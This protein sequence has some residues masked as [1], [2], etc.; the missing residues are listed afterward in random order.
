M[1]HTTTAVCGGLLIVLGLLTLFLVGSTSWSGDPLSSQNKVAC[2]L[3][4]VTLFPT[5]L[6][7]A[8]LIVE[9][10]LFARFTQRTYLCDNVLVCFTFPPPS[11]KASRVRIV[12]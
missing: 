11:P 2:V 5:L 6:C 12:Q 4:G 1:G 10:C 3:W 7:I 9:R 8:L